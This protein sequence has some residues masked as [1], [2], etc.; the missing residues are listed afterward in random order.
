MSIKKDTGLLEPSLDLIPNDKNPVNKTNTSAQP[1]WVLIIGCITSTVAIMILAI[2]LWAYKRR[3]STKAKN[4][5]LRKL[6]GWEVEVKPKHMKDIKVD[7]G[8]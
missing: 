7:I 4:N 6:K 1:K 2:S 5:V 8:N 3:D